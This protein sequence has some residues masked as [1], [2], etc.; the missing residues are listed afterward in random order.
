[1]KDRTLTLAIAL[2]KVVKNLWIYARPGSPKQA[3]SAATAQD[4]YV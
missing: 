3:S 2:K 4:S 1:M